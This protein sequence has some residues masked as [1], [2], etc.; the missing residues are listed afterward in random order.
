MTLHFNC[1]PDKPKRQRLRNRAPNAERHLWPHLRRRHIAGAKF[2]RQY[3]V[4]RFVI[5]FYCP[6][7]KL[8]I[9]IDG[10]SH[11]GDEAQAYDQARQ[12]HIEALGIEFLR[13]TN[14]QVY[15]EL[16][17]VVVAIRQRVLELKAGADPS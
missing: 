14:A 13:F 2:R 4:D 17:E 10:S 12:Q 8:A 16:E 7:L 3:G 6:A 11:D 9:E 15:Q 5:D 1:T